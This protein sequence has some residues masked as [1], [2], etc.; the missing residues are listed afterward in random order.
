MDWYI[1]RL[2][3]KKN[4]YSFLVVG[5]GGVAMPNCVLDNQK[6]HDSL[7]LRNTRK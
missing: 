5:G 4:K 2:G 3:R 1:A 6:G 7:K